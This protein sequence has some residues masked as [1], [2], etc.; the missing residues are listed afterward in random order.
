MRG[1][2]WVVIV[3]S[4]YLCS[5]VGYAD[6]GRIS[7]IPNIERSSDIGIKF[8]ISIWAGAFCFPGGGGQIRTPQDPPPGKVKNSG[9]V[10]AK[11][12]ICSLAMESTKKLTNFFSGLFSSKTAQNLRRNYT[13]LVP[14]LSR[15]PLIIR[16]VDQKKLTFLDF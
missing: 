13:S 8:K 7:N 9:G 14:V 11:K 2:W 5:S 12:A 1:P 6:R 16:T 4:C 10:R 3:M 15:T